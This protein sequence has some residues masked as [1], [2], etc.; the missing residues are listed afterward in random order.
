MS[1]TN[2]LETGLSF[3]NCSFW[4]VR[5]HSG[6]RSAPIEGRLFLSVKC[7]LTFIVLSVAREDYGN[8][9]GR[10]RFGNLGT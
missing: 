4:S 10:L 2:V 8:I 7:A 6:S 5:A 1:G 9:I 3:V